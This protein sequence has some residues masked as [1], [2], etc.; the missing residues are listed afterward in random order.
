MGRNGDYHAVRR[1]GVRYGGGLV[2][3]QM[4]LEDHEIAMH[5]SGAYG[6]AKRK[7]AIAMLRELAHKQQRNDNFPTHPFPAA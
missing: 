4:K 6:T 7:E 1:R 2:R 3:P 5:F